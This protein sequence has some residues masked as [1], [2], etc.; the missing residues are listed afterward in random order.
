MRKSKFTEEQI[1]FALRQAEAGT[2]VPDVARKLGV[3]EE[4]A[5]DNPCRYTGFIGRSP[6]DNRR[7]SPSPPE[8]TDRSAPHLARGRSAM[9]PRATHRSNAPIPPRAR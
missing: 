5:S 2:P 7:R 4:T 3:S 8:P 6:C 1:A 9:P